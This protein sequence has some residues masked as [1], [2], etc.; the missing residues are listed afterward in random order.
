MTK[1]NLYVQRIELE[2]IQGYLELNSGT[3]VEY[4]KHSSFSPMRVHISSKPP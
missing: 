3:R 4:A 1:S 2:M